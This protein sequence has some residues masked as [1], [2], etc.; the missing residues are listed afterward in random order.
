[1][2]FWKVIMVFGILATQLGA[3]SSAKEISIPVRFFGTKPSI[4][5]GLETK[6]FE[7]PAQAWINPFRD[8]ARIDDAVFE[9]Y[10]VKNAHI[11][12][13]FFGFRIGGDPQPLP[14]FTSAALE[15]AFPPDFPESCCAV[16]L[17]ANV[18]EGASLRFERNG[19]GISGHRV[20][21]DKSPAASPFVYPEKQ[22]KPDCF[23]SLKQL[24]DSGWYALK[25]KTVTLCGRKILNT[26]VVPHFYQ[27][28][29][30]LLF[31]PEPTARFKSVEIDF[32]PPSRKAV[33]VRTVPKISGVKFPLPVDKVNGV[34]SSQLSRDE[35]ARILRDKSDQPVVIE[36]QGKQIELPAKQHDKE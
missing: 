15:T 8:G 22:K 36:A 35:L 29:V 10:G 19:P 33:I 1:M 3:Y 25:E 26:L 21:W 7:I 5:V 2:S 6:A 27:K 34:R 17:G 12:G 9:D 20:W 32:L 30:A 23:V 14:R 16:D 13:K 18:W 24:D 4:K 31:L 28:T 11:P